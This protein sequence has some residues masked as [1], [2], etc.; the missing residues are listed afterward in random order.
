[1]IS[2]IYEENNNRNKEKVKLLKDIKSKDKTINEGRG[3]TVLNKPTKKYANV[4]GGAEITEPEKEVLNIGKKFRLYTQGTQEKDQQWINLS[5]C[6][7][8]E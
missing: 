8:K 5:N 2:K 1:M 7:L 3:D 4:W 6:I